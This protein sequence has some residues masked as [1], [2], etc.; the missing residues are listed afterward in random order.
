MQLGEGIREIVTRSNILCLNLIYLE[1]S[2]FPSALGS[3]FAEEWWSIQETSK[4]LQRFLKVVQQIE[5]WIKIFPIKP[6]N[7]QG[8]S[9]YWLWEILR[10]VLWRQIFL[11]RCYSACSYLPSDFFKHY[12]SAKALWENSYWAWRCLERENKEMGMSIQQKASLSR[13]TENKQKHKCLSK[14]PSSASLIKIKCSGVDFTFLN[15]LLNLAPSWPQHHQ[16]TN[17]PGFTLTLF[18]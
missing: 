6:L 12:K 5:N 18:K 10:E 15:F 13:V 1:T 14:A 9:Q 11:H 16:C 3:I 4:L 2:G 17:P 7:H 8:S